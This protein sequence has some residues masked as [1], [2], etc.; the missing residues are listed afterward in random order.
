[1]RPQD[2]PRNPEVLQRWFDTPAGRMLSS[3][4][5]MH[6]VQF[7][8]DYS[9]TKGAAG[10]T[11]Y[12]THHAWSRQRL[13]L[14]LEDPDAYWVWTRVNAEDDFRDAVDEAASDL[15]I[16]GVE[17]QEFDNADSFGPDDW[18]LLGSVIVRDADRVDELIDRL[19][20]MGY[21]LAWDPREPE[22]DAGT[23]LCFDLTSW[24][25]ARAGGLR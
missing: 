9:Y 18:G 10:D 13:V 3:G 16:E 12:L 25:K 6:A 1:M 2:D 21:E 22:A 8:C 11:W 7:V 23:E 20:D 24:T 19:D 14:A 15:C 4:S 5:A 17:V